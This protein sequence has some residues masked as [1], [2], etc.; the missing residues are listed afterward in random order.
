[1]KVLVISPDRNHALRLPEKPI[2]P[3]L[4][5]LVVAGLFDRDRHEVRFIDE[6]VE[7]VSPDEPAD[8][9]CLTSMTATAPRAY[10]IAR[11]FRARGVRTVMGGIHASFR[12]HEAAGRCDSVVVGEAEA[13]FPELL[14]DLERGRPRRIYGSLDA[15]PPLV[16]QPLP[17]HD[18]LHLDRYFIA[19]VAETRRGCPY[20]CDFCTVKNMFGRKVRDLDIDR[21]IDALEY[22]AAVTGRHLFFADDDFTVQSRQA[23]AFCRRLIERQVRIDWICQSDIKVADHPDLVELM[24]R[25][26]CA[27]MFVGYESLRP[28]AALRKLGRAPDLARSLLDRTRAIQSHGLLIQGGFVFGWDHD[29]VDVFDRTLDFIFDA[30]LDFIQA[31]T[32]TPFP[33]TELRDRLLAEGRIAYPADRDVGEWAR[34]N[35]LQAVIRPT[36]MS[37]DELQE[38]VLRVWRTFYSTKAAAGRLVKNTTRCFRGVRPVREALTQA[39]MKTLFDLNYLRMVANIDR[40]YKSFC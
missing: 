24:V 35:F 2:F 3:L 27:G 5:P 19:G 22:I 11:E 39:A 1:M 4:G 31:S 37:Y 29:T 28:E 9:V 25:A 20:D 33:G 23:A 32:L 40:S 12:P 10:E 38:G 18:L 26:G 14:A 17:R 34:Y 21:A 16:D 8:L 30:R 15:R 7:P 13:V 36:R 6:T